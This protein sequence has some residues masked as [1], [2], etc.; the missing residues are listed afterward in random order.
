MDKK[1]KQILFQNK[2]NLRKT[3]SLTIYYK[4]ELPSNWL[5]NK[6]DLLSA[7]NG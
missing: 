3:K 6:H 7:I 4:P 2:N 5:K 1:I